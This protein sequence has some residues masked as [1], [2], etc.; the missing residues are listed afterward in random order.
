MDQAR[1]LTAELLA[2]IRVAGV[3]L[4]AVAPELAERLNGDPALVWARG[5]VQPPGQ[6]QD[7]NQEPQ[8]DEGNP[9]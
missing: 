9:E 3:D 5:E 1:G 6:W 7:P 4:T 8:Q 2:V